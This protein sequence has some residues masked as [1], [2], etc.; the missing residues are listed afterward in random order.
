MLSILKLSLPFN[1]QYIEIDLKNLQEL[2]W[3][4]ITE[5]QKL[6]VYKFRIE[7]HKSVK[8]FLLSYT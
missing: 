5:K 8:F 3:D 2:N 6:N 1:Q 4:E 7:V